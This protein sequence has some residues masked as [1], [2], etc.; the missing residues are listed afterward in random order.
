LGAWKVRSCDS[1]WSS[2]L[3]SRRRECA[4]PAVPMLRG[5]RAVRTCP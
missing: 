4:F 1:H 3:L 2:P 5:L